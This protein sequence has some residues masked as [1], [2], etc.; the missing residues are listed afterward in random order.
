MRRTERAVEIDVRDDG[1]TRPGTGGGSGRGIVGMHERA[2]LLGGV[3]EAG[4]RPGGGWAVH[5][6]LPCDPGE[7]GARSALG[8]E[9]PHRDVHDDDGGRP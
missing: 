8:L 4:P 6:V 5:V 2:A 7:S 9:H 3:V 1:G